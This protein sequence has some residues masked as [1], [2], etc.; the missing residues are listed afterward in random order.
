MK[1]NKNKFKNNKILLTNIENLT[2][3]KVPELS[4]G[5]IYTSE[6]STFFTNSNIYNN[7]K[8]S[9]LE[10]IPTPLSPQKTMVY[11]T[12]EDSSK[13]M[14]YLS[15]INLE[16]DLYLTSLKKKLSIIKEERK[17]SELNV[18]NLKRRIFELQKEEQKSLRQLENT[19]KYIK[20][21]IDNRKKNNNIKKNYD[22]K[23]TKINNFFQTN[24]SPNNKLLNTNSYNYKTWFAP[25]KKRNLI[26]K[27]YITHINSNS[28]I[29]TN[30]NNNNSL[31]ISNK[32]IRNTNNNIFISGNKNIYSKKKIR[33]N[34]KM[35]NNNYIKI[36]KSNKNTNRILKENL[37]RT[38][39][40]DEEEKI[41]IE[42]QIEEIEKEQNSLFNNFYSNLVFYRS[43]KTLDL[44]ENNIN[45]D[46]L[47]NKYIFPC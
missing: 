2:Y 11:N 18:T 40:K 24:K 20:R 1:S 14:F 16:H 34:K 27:Q 42:K 26:K 29:E 47:K 32:F 6:Y 19:K 41:K 13:E 4:S 10:L 35:N 33:I 37:I 23:I 28:G 22:I 17:Q 12:I 45:Y 43:S 31:S 36:Y 44:E 3:K 7:S 9:N 21:I 30:F 5:N 46:K 38:L 39:K 25:S 15:K 8:Y